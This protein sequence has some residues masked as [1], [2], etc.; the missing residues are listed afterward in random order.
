MKAKP[1]VAGALKPNKIKIDEGNEDIQAI[2]SLIPPVKMHGKS[3]VTFGGTNEYFTGPNIVN[4]GTADYTIS[5]WVY[6]PSYK[7][8]LYWDD[9]RKNRHIN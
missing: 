7:L 4:V 1:I 6:L 3:V 5:S 2:G 9:K 8:A